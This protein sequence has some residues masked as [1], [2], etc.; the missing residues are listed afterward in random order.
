[1]QP[2]LSGPKGSWGEINNRGDRV[3]CACL[4]ES[5]LISPKFHYAQNKRVWLEQII[6]VVKG[7]S[8]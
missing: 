8:L 1:M 7:I 5:I 3:M 4:L 6:G 2:V